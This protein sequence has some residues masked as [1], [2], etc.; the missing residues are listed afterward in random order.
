MV[1]I[2][3]ILGKDLQ[4]AGFTLTEEDDHLVRL[5]YQGGAVGRYSAK[6]VTHSTLIADCR[7]L[8]E[9]NKRGMPN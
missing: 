3:Y 7:K 2:S 1:D 5:D 4:S 6:G 9:A 8:L